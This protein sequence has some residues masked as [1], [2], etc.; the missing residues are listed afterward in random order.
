MSIRRIYHKGQ[1]FAET[2]EIIKKR[3]I[4]DIIFKGKELDLL[5]NEEY[6]V[7]NMDKPHVI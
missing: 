2:K 4:D 5:E 3:F 7:I 6:K 1:T